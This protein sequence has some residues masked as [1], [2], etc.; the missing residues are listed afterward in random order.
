MY[1]CEAKCSHFM[2]RK[3]RNK[4]QRRV[5]FGIFCCGFKVF[6]L[7]IRNFGEFFGDIG[8]ETIGYWFCL[9]DIIIKS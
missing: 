4:L 9:G 1:H 6:L 5:E 2:S 3:I 7:Q 8:G